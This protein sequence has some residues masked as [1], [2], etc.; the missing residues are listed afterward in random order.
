MFW[1]VFP[2]L[3]AFVPISLSSKRRSWPAWGAVGYN[4][5]HTIVVWV[6]VFFV[7]WALAGAP[8][9]PIFGW[10]VHITFDR[11][12]GYGLRLRN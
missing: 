11:S 4:V 1:G 5:F 7:V 12:V 8:Y 9:W 6:A 2:D 10:L 3:A